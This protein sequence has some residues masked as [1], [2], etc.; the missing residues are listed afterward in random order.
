MASD[1]LSIA[2][3][4][5]KAARAALDVTSQNIANA[6]TAGYVRRSVNLQEM[7]PSSAYGQVG[8]LSGVRLAGVTRNVDSFRLAEVSW[9]SLFALAIPLIWAIAHILVPC[10]STHIVESK[11][12]KLNLNS[13]SGT[14]FADAAD[15]LA[16]QPAGSVDVVY[17]DPM[18]PDTGKSAAAKK[19]MQAFQVVVGDDLDAGRLLLVA[20][21]VAGK[22]VVV[23]RPRL[24]ALLTGEKPA[25]QQ[26][27]KSTRFDLYAPL[28]SASA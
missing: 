12:F 23:K 21:Q 13:F 10:E 19:E 11:S 15:W 24:G 20:R 14:V 1:L 28:P 3:S 7:P 16:Q 5:A 27:G 6:S 17:L 4:G 8:S 25:G 18:F 9:W 26:V 2:S 22:R